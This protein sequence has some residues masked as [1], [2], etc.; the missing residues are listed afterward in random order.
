MKSAGGATLLK[1]DDDSILAG[2]VNPPSDEY[3]V[4]FYVPERMEIH[5]IRL[6]ALLHDSLPGKGPGRSTKGYEGVFALF[7]WDLTAQGP[8]GADSPQLFR[9]RTACA[10]YS[11]RGDPLR[12]IGEWNISSASGKDHTSIWSLHDPVT[13]E[14]GTLLRSQNAIQHEP[15]LGRSE[16]RSIS[17]IRLR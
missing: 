3:T 5:S 16:S 8:D 6:E 14:A 13:L 9:F 12:S 2:G 7:R 15:G 10:D 17:N 4:A 11:W 1:L